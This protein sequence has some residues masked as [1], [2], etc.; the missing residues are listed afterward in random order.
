MS[1]KPKNKRKLG[2]PLIKRVKVRARFKEHL[3]DDGKPHPSMRV[4]LNEIEF[5]DRIYSPNP[6]SWVKM[7]VVSICPLNREYS[8]FWFLSS[9]LFVSNFFHPFPFPKLTEFRNRAK[10]KKL[11]LWYSTE[12][13]LVKYE[14]IC[15]NWNSFQITICFLLKFCIF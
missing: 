12:V 3:I 1:G 15:I 7:C 11:L 5:Y 8:L 9:H 14:D 2:T 6:H 10:V 13:E 4:S